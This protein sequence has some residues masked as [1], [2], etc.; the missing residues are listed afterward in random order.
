[1][2]VG[3]VHDAVVDPLGLQ[4]LAP[5]FGFI[6]PVRYSL[7]LEG[8]PG[9]GEGEG[10]G[11]PIPPT[12]SSGPQGPPTSRLP[13][14]GGVMQWRIA[15]AAFPGGVDTGHELAE[16][17]PLDGATAGPCLG[18]YPAPQSSGW[19]HLIFRPVMQR[20]PQ[21]GSDGTAQGGSDGT[22]EPAYTDIPGF[23]KSATIEEIRK[24]GHVLTP[25]RYVGAAPQEDD[26]EPFEEKMAR[27]TKQWR[28]QQA[29]ARRLDAAIEENL[30]RLGFGTGQ[31][32]RAEG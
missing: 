8:S 27:L 7:S 1:M 26:G 11:A 32:S 19:R 20:S 12:G 17:L 9:W 4:P 24:H 13:L 29:E 14:K 2:L 15:G 22:G 30:A 23:C 16:P 5:A 18:A 28:E 3:T 10:G 25:G 6:R 21:G 31:G